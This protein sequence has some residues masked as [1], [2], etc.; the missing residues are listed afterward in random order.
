MAVQTSAGS[1]LSIS[2]ALPATYD[3][4]GFEALTYTEVGEIT[5][6]GEFGKEF[7]LV[8]H[9]ALGNRKT[10]KFKGSYN[11]GSLPLQLG[12][13]TSDAGQAAMN[14]AQHSDNDYSF[15]VVLQD[16][17][18]SYFVGKVMSF[19]TVVGSVDQVTGA[20]STIEI[21]DDVVEVAA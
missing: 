14:L 11:N 21:S 5:D 6:L 8:T 15:R 1:T 17:A 20:T 7:N 4:A 10:R 2:S 9:V 18:S 19:R 16:G 13:D 3:E 12:R